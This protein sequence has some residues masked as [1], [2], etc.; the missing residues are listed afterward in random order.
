MT[1]KMFTDKDQGTAFI[2][3]T[4]RIKG[5]DI[6]KGLEDLVSNPFF[7]NIRKNLV[8]SSTADFSDV[9]TDEFEACASYCGTGFKDLRIVI[10]AP[11]DLSFGLGR[12]FA[13]LS[14]LEN[15]LVTRTMEEAISWLDVTL[16]EEF[17]SQTD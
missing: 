13:T 17:E 10:V 3:Y 5:G 12:M 7:E 15:I 9:L 8:D 11:S 1:T 4:G 2:K 14:N 16:P 6:K